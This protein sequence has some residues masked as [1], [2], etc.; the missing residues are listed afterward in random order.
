MQNIYD[1]EYVKKLFNQM[2]GSYERM[3]SITSF[4]FSIIWRKQFL[5]K[6][7]CYSSEIHV[8]DLLSG[9]GENWNTL[10]KRYPNATIHGLDFSEEMILKSQKKNE[11]SF[12]NC[13]NVHQQDLLNNQLPSKY[14]DIVSCAFGLKT[15]NSNQLEV[16]GK[17]LHTILNNNGQFSFIEISV[18]ENKILKFLFG[19]YLGKIIPILGKLFLG[20]PSD[21]KMLW[22]YTSKFKN[23]R[24]VQKI[25]EKYGLEVNYHSYFFGCATGI[26]GKKIKC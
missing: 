18:P 22:N 19:L 12:Q 14:F 20:N 24:E 9:L 10:K 26:S 1:P 7:T 25:F 21:Y 5:N 2:S 11:K 17:T 23:C 6:L 8:I 15:F 3:N 4:G 16:L 13:I